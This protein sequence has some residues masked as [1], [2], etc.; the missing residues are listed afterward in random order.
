VRT[1]HDFSQ[2]KRATILRRIARRAQVTRKETLAEYYAHLRETP[3][4][5]PSAF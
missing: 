2:Y 5:I 4:G 1:G 3:G